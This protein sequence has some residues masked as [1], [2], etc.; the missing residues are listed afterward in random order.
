MSHKLVDQI[1]FEM[2]QLLQ[3]LARGRSLIELKTVQQPDFTEQWALGAMLQAFYNGIENILKRI[4]VNFEGKPV[5]TERWHIDLLT[6]MSL[7]AKNRPA[8]ISEQ[9]LIHLRKYLAFRHMFRSIY[10]HELRWESM[11]GLAAAIDDTLEM[12]GNELK[13]F[14]KNT[15]LI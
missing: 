11:A 9:L 12:F 5:K 6:Q 15:H 7:A 2:E 8:V 13:I 1:D 14:I 3:L 4:A 10:T